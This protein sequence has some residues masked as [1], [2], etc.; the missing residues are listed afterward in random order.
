MFANCTEL[1]KKYPNG[2]P[3]GHPAYQEKMDRDHDNYACE[4]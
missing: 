4:R 3:K 1:R 2:V